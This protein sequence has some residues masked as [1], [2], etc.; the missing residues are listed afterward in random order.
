MIVQSRDWLP[1]SV[2]MDDVVRD[3]IRSAVTLWSARW[4]VGEPVVVS[5]L[6]ASSGAARNESDDSGWRVCRAAIAIRSDRPALSRMVGR[7]LDTHTEDMHLTEGDQALLQGM[8]RRILD[9]LSETLEQAFSLAGELKRKPQKIWDPLCEGGGLLASLV[10]TS[11]REILSF[12]L[13]THVI[14]PHIK[15][16]LGPVAQKTEALQP[17]TKTLG[18]VPVSIEALIGSA[19]LSLAEFND[20]AVGDV[21][22]LDR[23]LDQPV[24]ITGAGSRQIFAKARLTHVDDGMALVFNA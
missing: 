9:D 18:D 13:P 2:I 3:A 7:A 20:L 17:L 14:V 1:L 5:G 15:A 4:F 16:H 10:E 11:G 23:A 24:D 12:A 22:V 6:K 8:E 21:L 19:E